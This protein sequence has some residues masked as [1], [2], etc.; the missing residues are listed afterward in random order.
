MKNGD[1]ILELRNISLKRKEFLDVTSFGGYALSTINAIEDYLSA[2]KAK[3]EEEK[4]RLEEN[5]RQAKTALTE[6]NENLN[7][8]ILIEAVNYYLFS[9]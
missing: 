1:G 3:D 5:L 2:K 7:N 9:Q 8:P 4:I 6:L